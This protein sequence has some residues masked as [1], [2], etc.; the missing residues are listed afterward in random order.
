M[1]EGR[2]GSPL[3]QDVQFL[4]GGG[5]IRGDE[6][7]GSLEQRGAQGHRRTYF[8]SKNALEQYISQNTFS[9]FGPLMPGNPP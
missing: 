7:E 9:P 1:V 8:Y 2:S 3:T 6:M 4:P 5:Q